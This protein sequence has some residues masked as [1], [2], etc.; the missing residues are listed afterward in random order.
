MNSKEFV[1][2]TDELEKYYDKELNSTER[3]TWFEELNK[4][5]KERYRQ[6]IRE[7][8]KNNKFMP[9]LA[10]IL[11]LHRTIPLPKREESEVVECK[12]CKSLGFIL[13]DQLVEDYKYTFAAKCT[14]LNG[15]KYQKYP[16]IEE[17]NLV[18]T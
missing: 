13:Y 4:L 1:E 6:I 11:S 16:S 14:C 15:R 3:K 7:C 9:K 12:I 5:P 17:L 2:L 18:H 10:D 8:F